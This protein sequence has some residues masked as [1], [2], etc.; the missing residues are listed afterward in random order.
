MTKSK[1]ILGDQW[2]YYKIYGGAKTID[3]LLTETLKPIIDDFITHNVIDQWF[4]I[5]Y[6]DPDYHIRLRFHFKNTTHL[7]KVI[8][9]MNETLTPLLKN[10]TIYKV[11]LDT[12][13]R[14]LL[15]YGKNTIAIA[16]NFFY[17]DSNGIASAL[18][19]IEDDKIRLLFA[20]KNTNDLL[21]TFGLNT[22]QK[23]DFVKVQMHYFKEEFQANK[24]T[25]KQLAKKYSDNK[26]EIIL[27]IE[28]AT[29]LSTYKEL[30]TLLK[31]KQEKDKTVY[32]QLQNQTKTPNNLLSSLIHMSI[33]RT[34]R[35]KQRLHELLHY[36][37]LV[38]HYKTQLAKA[39]YL[40]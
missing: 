20:L 34:F 22:K 2:M 25:N 38:R 6:T 5:R 8:F 29:S 10:D 40:S 1:F 23:L 30:F 28:N 9:K 36:Y 16:E 14:E 4:F 21:Q 26:Q 7:S 39:K 15:R 11:Q 35:S 3:L 33:N 37:F 12:Y 31:A 32:K 19:L 24:K 13:H 17:N 18:Q 27:F